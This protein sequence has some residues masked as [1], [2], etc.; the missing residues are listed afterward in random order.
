MYVHVHAVTVTCVHV[1]CVHVLCVLAV[2]NTRTIS[3]NWSL[4]QIR[5]PPPTPD[6]FR[7]HTHPQHQGRALCAVG[8][9]GGRVRNQGDPRQSPNHAPSGV[10][11]I[12]NVCTQERIPANHEDRIPTHGECPYPA[13]TTPEHA[14]GQLR[15]LKTACKPRRSGLDSENDRLALFMYTY[16]IPG[17]SYS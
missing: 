10:L 7:P 11:L 14:D 5:N 12:P 17:L 3:L 13:H 6:D 9:V 16:I 15:L 8:M 1:L 4:L 2:P